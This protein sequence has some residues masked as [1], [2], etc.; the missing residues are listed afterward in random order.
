MVAAAAVVGA[1]IAAVS[2]WEPGKEQRSAEARLV[3]SIAAFAVAPSSSS[4]APQSSPTAS[5]PTVRVASFNQAKRALERIYADHRTT[6]YCGCR[7]DAARRIDLGSCGYTPKN[8]GSSRARRIEWEH[9]VAAEAFG[10]SFREW[11]EGHPECLDKR[12][13]P[14][15]GRNCARKMSTAFR[16]M[17][18]DMHN[19][20]PVIGELN[21]LRSNYSIAIICSIIGAP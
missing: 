2:L 8:A 5:T 1:G 4:S 6:F 9:V 13:K 18:A 10:Q 17:E 12:G 7:Y 14:F 11:R 20:Y 21:A 16:R 15:K 19:L 3:P